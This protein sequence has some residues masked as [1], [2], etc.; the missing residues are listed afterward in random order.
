MRPA[1]S[2]GRTRSNE[3]KQGD[4]LGT[5]V[6]LLCTAVTEHGMTY[7]PRGPGSRSLDSSRGSHAPPRR[8]RKSSTGPSQAGAFD[9]QAREVREMRSAE[10]VLGIIQERGK[11][12]LP[13]CDLY[14]HLYNPNLYLKAYG[15]I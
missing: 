5:Y 12:G 2:W 13:L 9:T 10:Q 7:R 8:T 1:P 14:R 11:R 6:V 3:D 15:K 4:E